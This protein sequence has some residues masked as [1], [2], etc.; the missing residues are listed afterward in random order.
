[1]DKSLLY[2]KNMLIMYKWSRAIFNTSITAHLR[3]DVFR[4]ENMI[5]SKAL[6]NPEF[7]IRVLVLKEVVGMT[8]KN[9]AYAI[10]K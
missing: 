9:L 1:M 8:G 10:I 6:H 3:K 5:Y 2:V 4:G 7:K